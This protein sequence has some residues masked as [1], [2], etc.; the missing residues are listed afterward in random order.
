MTAP[1]DAYPGRPSPAV[2]DEANFQLGCVSC[3]LAV[4]VEVP[5]ESEA[6]FLAEVEGF[7]PLT[8]LPVKA[9][10]KSPCGMNAV[11]GTCKNGEAMAMVVSL[12]EAGEFE[13]VTVRA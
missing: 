8:K 2:S 5:P 10:H 9:A 11:N 13:G 7:V 3:R 12:I 1:V 6:D 4:G